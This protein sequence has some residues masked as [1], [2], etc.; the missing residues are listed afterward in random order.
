MTMRLSCY[1]GPSLAWSV[2]D[3]QGRAYCGVGT[4]ERYLQLESREVGWIISFPVDVT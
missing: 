3:E 2:T 1:F 4:K